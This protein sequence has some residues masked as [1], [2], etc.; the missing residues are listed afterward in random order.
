VVGFRAGAADADRELARASLRS[1][2]GDFALADAQGEYAVELAAAGQYHV[3]FLSRYQPRDDS[4]FLEPALQQ[5]LSTYF[6]RPANVIGGVQY[7]LGTFRFNG[8]APSTRDQLFDR[9]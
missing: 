5:L 2:G 7:Q 3:L 1:L 6:D 4:E 8:D 9:E